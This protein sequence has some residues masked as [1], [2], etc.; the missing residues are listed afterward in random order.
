MGF[1]NKQIAKLFV[2]ARDRFADTDNEI[3]NIALDEA[4]NLYD[5]YDDALIPAGMAEEGQSF[6]S[7][8]S[9]KHGKDIIEGAFEILDAQMNDGGNTHLIWSGCKSSDARYLNKT[10]NIPLTKLYLS[11][12]AGEEIDAV[13]NQDDD[14][15]G[16][17]LTNDKIWGYIESA[18]KVGSIKPEVWF[19]SLIDGGSST[20]LNKTRGDLGY[21]SC[22]GGA[23]L[24]E[25][26]LKE[27][28]R[29]TMEPA[30]Q[31]AREDEVTQTWG[32]EE[33]TWSATHMVKD[34]EETAKDYEKAQKNLVAFRKAAGYAALKHDIEY[35]EQCF[36]L[37]NIQEFAAVKLYLDHVGASLLD[38]KILPKPHEHNSSLMLHGDPYNLMNRLTQSPHKEAFFEM[39]TQAISALQPMIRLFKI[40]SIIM[41]RNIKWK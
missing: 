11:T 26:A 9:S 5:V 24:S 10:S 30:F 16:W 3:W 2:D 33:V 38:R 31:K 18:D 14:W 29:V 19:Q 4:K 36:L 22:A 7:W 20:T 13:L 1:S 37:S 17:N 35:K 8:K 27:W 41:A 28:I 6:D 34:P 21:D 40:E 15:P 32:D 25:A 12:L 39:P 23:E